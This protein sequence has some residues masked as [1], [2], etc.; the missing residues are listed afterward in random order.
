MQ[1]M[2]LS[3]TH[4]NTDIK[5]R[6]KLSFGS[7]KEI[8][9][10]LRIII[11]H[12]NVNEAIMLST[13]NRV[14]VITSVKERKDSLDFILRA[15]SHISGIDKEVLESRADVYDN[16]GAIH[17]LFAVCSSLDSLVIGE[18]QI[19]GQLKE[20]F[21]LALK[22]GFCGA[23]LSRAMQKCF[24][25]AAMVRSGTDI[26]KNPVSV[27]SVAVTKAKELIGTLEGAEALVIGAGEMSELAAK[28]L[29][30]SGGRVTLIN[31]NYENALSLADKLGKNV[32]VRPFSDLSSAINEYRLLFSATGATRPI[33]TDDMTQDRDFDRYWFDIAV[34]RDIDISSRKNISVYAVDDLEEI[35][36]KNLALR[37]EQAKAAY[38]IV[39]EMTAEFL[40]QLQVLS[41]GPIIKEIRNQAKESAL[42]E[43]NKAIV[44]G[45]IGVEQKENVEKILHQAF[46]NFLHKPTI[47]LKNVSELTDSDNIVRSLQ[48][49]FD[50]NEEML[51]FDFINNLNLETE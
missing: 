35:V 21:N 38:G 26:S 24:K 49:F 50:I 28:H 11:S 7:E 45:Y 44:K 20:A 17:H 6:E 34:P 36:A 22:N 48:Y 12:I 37:E 1:Y 33:V 3:F 2:T 15:L 30:A 10:V 27:S 16:A 31:R 18:T 41:V 4:K 23:K 51:K 46:N 9:D 25:C 19:A 32:S 42:R 13:C 39:G 8:L 29:I 40:K 43:I 14:E 47:N 5:T